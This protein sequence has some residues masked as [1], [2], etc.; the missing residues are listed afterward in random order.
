MI[1]SIIL[2]FKI[3]S[4]IVQNQ[5]LFWDRKNSQFHSN[6]IISSF[7]NYFSSCLISKKLY[8]KKMKAVPVWNS[9]SQTSKNIK[10]GC[11]SFKN[12]NNRLIYY[13]TSK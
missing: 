2:L 13:Y 7:A 1:L 5:I 8:Y 10:K 4:F 6:T 11:E 9:F 3:K 12:N